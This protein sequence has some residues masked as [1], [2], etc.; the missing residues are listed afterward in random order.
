MERKHMSI[1]KILIK[2][3]Y[4]VLKS[5]LHEILFSLQKGESKQD[6]LPSPSNLYGDIETYTLDLE[7]RNYHSKWLKL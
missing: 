7:V 1:N 4:L 5:N 2:C 3:T 6:M